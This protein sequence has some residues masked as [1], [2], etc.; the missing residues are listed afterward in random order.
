MPINVK[1]GESQGDFIGRCMSEEESSFPNEQQRYAICIGYWS[2]SKMSKMKQLKEMV[3]NSTYT[4]K[5][6]RK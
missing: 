4:A 6:N 3:K 1:Q 5:S 2:E